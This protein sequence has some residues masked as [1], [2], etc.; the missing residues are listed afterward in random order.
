MWP[1]F[2]RLQGLR[3][4]TKR[5]VK[6]YS[7]HPTEYDAYVL[8][9]D[10]AI[11]WCSETIWKKW[12]LGEDLGWEN[13]SSWDCHPSALF[14]YSAYSERQLPPFLHCHGFDGSYLEHK[15]H[16]NLRRRVLPAVGTVTTV[17]R[18]NWRMKWTLHINET[19][20]SCQ[21]YQIE[22]LFNQQL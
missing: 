6:M 14:W 20:V 4:V 13:V 5:K 3:I 10:R 22:R 11:A 8:S 7:I 12:R 18:K 17:A 15:P 16:T 9:R 19:T 21:G 2:K 1:Y